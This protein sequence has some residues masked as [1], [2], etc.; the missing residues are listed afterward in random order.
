[1]PAMRHEPTAARRRIWPACALLALL[2]LTCAARAQSPNR[3]VG[4]PTPTPTPK[5]SPAPAGAGPPRD[6]PKKDGKKSGGP[7]GFRRSDTIVGSSEPAQSTRK[8]V[9]RAVEVP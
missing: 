9:A 5:P 4:R 7:G 6:A 8:D 3:E 1:M 2:C